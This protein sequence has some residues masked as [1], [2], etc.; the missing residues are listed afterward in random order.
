MQ[1]EQLNIIE[2]RLKETRRVQIR[3]NLALLLFYIGAIAVC[4]L[5]WYEGIR[6]LIW[7]GR[8]IVGE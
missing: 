2:K 7:I 6:L 4:L 3:Y 1:N 8:K 5:M